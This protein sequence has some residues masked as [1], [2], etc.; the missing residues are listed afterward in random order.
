MN[1]F[2]YPNAHT[3][4]QVD[5]Y[6]GTRVEDPFRWL[7]D[8]DSQDTLRWIKQENELTFSFLE[9]IPARERIHERLTKL[10]DYNRA[11]SIHKKGGRYFQFINS[12][13][14]NQDVLY[15]F[16]D[17]KESPRLLL[18]PNLLS[19]DG[20]VALNSWSISPDGKWL[21]YAISSSGSDWQTWQV[22][23]VDS[24]EDLPGKLEWSKF[25]GATWSRDG[26][27]FYYCPF[28]APKEG[29]VYQ[30]ANYNQ[31]ISFHRLNTSQSQD[32]LV[33]ERPDQPE[34]GF[35]TQVSDDGRYLLITV[36]QGTDTRNRFFY[37]VLGDDSAVV[38]LLPEL[39]ATYTFIGND[40]SLFYFQTNL[41]APRSR[42]IAIDTAHPERTNWKVLIP[43]AGA[44]LQTAQ[45]IHNQF[46]LVYLQDAHDVI[47]LFNLDGQPAGEV[48]LPTLGSVMVAYESSLHGEREDDEMF[49]GFHSFIHP[50][51]IF[52]YDFN[53]GLSTLVFKP[54][55]R[56][57]FTAYQTEQVF[58]T[59]KD[60][61]RVPMFL[62]HRRD[63]VKDGNNP[64]ILYGY[65]GFNLSQTP[66]FAISRLVWME[67][68]GVLAVANL[69]GGGEYGEAWHQAG[70]L[71][72]KQNVFDDF[73]ACAEWLIAQKVTSTPRL[74]IEGRSNGGLLVG[75]CLTQRPDLFAAA[76]PVVGVMDMLR[77]HKFTI[78]WAWVSDYGSAD[79]PQQ[80]LALRAYSPLH[81]LK[82][83]RRYPATLVLTSDHDDRVVPG[84]SFKFAARLQQCKAGEAPVLIR[85]QSSAGHGLG[86]PTS[87]WINEY[88]DMYAFLVEELGMQG[89]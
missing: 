44:V 46:V 1:K 51:T 66:A 20:T 23:S 53:L 47:R 7:E 30:E 37:K 19:P 18:D 24:G 78:G 40:G 36:F 61:T 52:R 86:K 33:Y 71:L 68:G 17:L 11:S 54:T 5:D 80:F 27:G 43:E 50:L 31:K 76:L 87:I 84:H 34:W 39:E 15:V 57:D 73:I 49:Y 35:G 69:R 41:D 8:V 14:Q 59:S 10:W 65:G 28:P 21:A 63:M 89:K 29:Q 64:T 22:R 48:Q 32:R 4:S 13:L 85:I 72:N 62:I 75:A 58:A 88:T 16:E 81:N 38:E 74:A 67:M 55:I 82:P 60:G 42:L 83:G 9:S 25:S 45:L 26:S 70:M 3:V 79:D 56:F 12:G 6:H 77:F 2:T